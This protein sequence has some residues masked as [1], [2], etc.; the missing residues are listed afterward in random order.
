MVITRPAYADST[1]GGVRGDMAI[2]RE[3]GKYHR[4]GMPVPALWTLKGSRMLPDLT[5]RGFLQGFAALGLSTPFASPDAALNWTGR[6]EMPVGRS[7]TPAAVIDGQV[8]V[9]GGFG[10]DTSAH[11]YDPAEDSWAQIADYPLPVNHPGIAVMD[12]RLLIGGGYGPDGGSAHKEIFAYEPA[13]DAWEQ[14]GALPLRMGAF[15]F[16]VLDE[17]LYLVGGAADFLGGPPQDGVARWDESGGL[18]KPLAP[19]PHPREHLAV[20]AQAGAVIAIGGRAHNLDATDLGAEATTYDPGADRWDELP[21]LPA[22][23]SGLSGA[24][25]CDGVVV[26]GGE[27]ST[28][29][30]DDV[31]FLDLNRMEWSAL[32]PLPVARHGIAVAAS[33]DSIFAIGG[34]TQAGRVANV[35]SVD[36]LSL[37]CPHTTP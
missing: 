28:E 18:W 19:L 25:V 27:T 16:A 9:V 23:R 5:R 26:I 12:G 21:P 4:P 8:Y 35:T 30:F 37:S 31:D 22:P 32:P 29:V 17:T 33:G 36:A 20:V 34:S 11:R 13:S 15:G 24:A 2:R 7:E 6:A 1:Y 3:R 10:A 14:V